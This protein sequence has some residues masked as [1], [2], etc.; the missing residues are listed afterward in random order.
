MLLP[1]GDALEQP[2]HVPAQVGHGLQA[3]GILLHL[4]GLGTVDVVPVGGGHHRHGADGEVLVDH[5]EGGGGA[6][7]PGAEHR[8]PGLEHEG[9]AA[10]VEGPVHEGQQPSAGVG[11]VHG[12]AEDEA[13]SLPGL[14]GE[15][16][17]AVVKD[18]SAGLPAAAA[19]YAVR[20]WL[21][22]NE[23]G[24]GVNALLLQGPGCL[25]QGYAGAAVGAGASVDQ[26]YFHGDSS[27][28]MVADVLPVL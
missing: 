20:Q 19:G 3:L 1:Q 26:Q 2:G 18:A 17:H 13:V 7:P 4:L 6:C 16:V 9:R 28:A 5:V 10:G 25:S 27:F 8:G 15:G 11:V 12:R 23:E 14:L 22:A 21:V 24:F